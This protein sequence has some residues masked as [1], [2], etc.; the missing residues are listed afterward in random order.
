MPLPAGGG[1][2]E[3]AALCEDLEDR[4]EADAAAGAEG[5]EAATGIE[6]ESAAEAADAFLLFFLVEPDAAAVEAAA[7]VSG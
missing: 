5:A 4:V 3:L 1:G 7:A 2:W 6:P